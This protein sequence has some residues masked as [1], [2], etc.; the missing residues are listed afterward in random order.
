MKRVDWVAG[1]PSSV[2]GPTETAGPYRSFG[3][4]G[5]PPS[6][7]YERQYQPR[8][9]MDPGLGNWRVSQNWGDGRIVVQPI[10]VGRF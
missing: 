9:D 10:I 3:Y 4:C 6:G 2:A 7:C 8:Y 1:S 5:T